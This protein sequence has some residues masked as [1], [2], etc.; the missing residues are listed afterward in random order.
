MSITRSKK[1]THDEILM[2]AKSKLNGSET[3]VSQ[4]TWNWHR[5]KSWRIYYNFEWERQIRENETKCD[6]CKW[7]EWKYEI[8]QGESRVLKNTRL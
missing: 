7:K 2:L 1:K 6:K 4:L 3:F 8:K 5:N